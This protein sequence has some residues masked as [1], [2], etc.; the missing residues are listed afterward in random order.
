MG[1][2]ADEYLTS[3]AAIK[4]HQD[5]ELKTGKSLSAIMSYSSGATANWRDT[6]ELSMTRFPPQ[7]SLKYEEQDSVNVQGPPS[8]LRFGVLPWENGVH[9]ATARVVLITLLHILRPCRPSAQ[10]IGAEL[11]VASDLSDT[12]RTSQVDVVYPIPTLSA[13]RNVSKV[14]CETFWCANTL[15]CLRLP[16]LETR[17]FWCSICRMIQLYR[18]CIAAGFYV[19][20]VASFTVV[21]RVT[22]RELVCNSAA[23][24]AV[25]AADLLTHGRATANICCAVFASYG[26]YPTRAPLT[27]RSLPSDGI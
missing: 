27:F 17:L 6:G 18:N 8:A 25:H 2:A 19:L 26:L 10:C 7:G 11:E 21:F 24:A 13:A 14:R 23:L 12:Y 1:T 3:L 5:T 16:V 15:S 9:A 22:D 4:Q 20:T